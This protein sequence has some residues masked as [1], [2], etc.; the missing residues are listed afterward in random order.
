MEIKCYKK[1]S[2]GKIAS[3]FYYCGF[4]EGVQVL[5]MDLRSLSSLIEDYALH[6]GDERTVLIGAVHEQDRQ[7]VSAK[8]LSKEI[9]EEIALIL[10]NSTKRQVIVA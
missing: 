4:C 7:N 1:D 6:D 8:P 10:H 5:G 2:G 9:L 3:K